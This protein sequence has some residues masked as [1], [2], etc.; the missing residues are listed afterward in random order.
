MRAGFEL[1][2][3]FDRDAE[4]NRTVLK[5]SE[6][7]TLPVLALGGEASFFVPVAKPMLQEVAMEQ[8]EP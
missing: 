8:S 2:R 5:K 4:D 6:R 3:A 1:Y 7:L